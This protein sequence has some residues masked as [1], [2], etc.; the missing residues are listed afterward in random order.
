M[1]NY[2]K[3]YALLCGAAS[4]AVVLIEKDAPNQ[5]AE[6]LK[7]ALLEAEELVISDGEKT[8]P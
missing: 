6:L 2:A 1:P 4:E 7:N 8:T 5:A 3:M